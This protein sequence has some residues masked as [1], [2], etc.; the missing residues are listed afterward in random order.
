M[1]T[2]LTGI[3]IKDDLLDRIHGYWLIHHPNEHYVK[4]QA[5]TELIEK[6]LSD[7]D[8][9]IDKQVYNKNDNQIDIHSVENIFN[10][11]FEK[12]IVELENKYKNLIAEMVN[13][14]INENSGHLKSDLN[15]S[16]TKNDAIPVNEKNNALDSEKT[17]H[18]TIVKNHEKFSFNQENN[19]GNT[20]E[21]NQSQLAKR[22][23]KS[24]STIN[25]HKKQTSFQDWSS[26]LDPDHQSWIYVDGKFIS[27]KKR[28]NFNLIN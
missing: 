27:Y 11:L 9:Q 28:T 16:I 12:K 1:V 23:G 19:T 24:E 20:I 26:E 25:R 18:D 10:H 4:A 3:R 13:K 21:L 2:K 14:T 7:N 17:H 5:I 6:G 22:L 15:Q 8:I